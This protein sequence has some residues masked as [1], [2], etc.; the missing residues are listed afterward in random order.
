M[1]RTP[2]EVAADDEALARICHEAHV[3]LRIGLNDSAEDVHFDAMDAERKEMNVS[4]IRMW[5]RGASPAEVHQAWREWMLARGWRYGIIRS[6]VSMTH[7]ALVDYADL[8]EEGKVKLHQAQAIVFCHIFPEA[9]SRM[10][11][12]HS[13]LA[14]ISQIADEYDLPG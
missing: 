7:P 5:R 11:R 12:Q 4:E 1:R 9:L 13:L 14:E 6:S 2:Q 10:I 3:A 8:P